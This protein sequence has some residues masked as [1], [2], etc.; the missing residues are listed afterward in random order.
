MSLEAFFLVP[1][2]QA[3]PQIKKELLKRLPKKVRLS[4]EE[5]MQEAIEKE[6]KEQSVIFEDLAKAF[7][8]VAD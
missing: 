6:Q 8:V 7:N 4:R 2:Q 1:I 3:L 5:L